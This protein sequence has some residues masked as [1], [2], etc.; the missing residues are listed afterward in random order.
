MTSDVF[1]FKSWGIGVALACAGR[2][3]WQRGLCVIAEIR[4][5]HAA[6]HLGLERLDGPSPKA[7]LFHKISF[8]SQNLLDST[9]S[10]SFQFEK[11]VMRFRELPLEDC[12]QVLVTGSAEYL[13]NSRVKVLRGQFRD[14]FNQI[15]FF[16]FLQEFNVADVRKSHNHAQFA[17]RFL[18]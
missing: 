3:R 13:V 14:G 16:T 7:N 1:I 12:I 10:A 15:D 5:S 6:K 18:H 4:R 17:S 9:F 8:A 11:K 2:R